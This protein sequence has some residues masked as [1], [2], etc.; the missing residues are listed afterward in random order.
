M[1]MQYSKL[2]ATGLSVSRLCL[3]TMT[4]GRQCDEQA[5][6]AILDTALEG[7]ITFL[8]TASS[9]PM[10]SG[11][12]E[13]GRTEEILGRWL[14][15]RRQAVVLATKGGSRIGPLPWQAGA[16]RKHLLDAIDGSLR[17]LGTDYVDLY[18]VHHDDPST[19]LEETME[20][21]DTIVRTGKARYV[22]AS[23][24][25]AYRLALALGRSEARRLVKFVSVQPRYNLLFREV[26]RELFPLAAEE[27]I[28]VN[29][30]N[31]LAGGLLTGKYRSMTQDMP[32]DSR[33]AS[34][35]GKAN[36]RERYWHER[37]FATLEAVRAEAEKAG[38]S[39][40][41]L[42]VAWALANPVVTSAIIG[43][44]RPGQLTDSLVAAGLALDGALKARLDELTHEY[45]FGDASR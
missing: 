28:A 14:K 1:S 9:Y 12:E 21:L 30:Y 25:L 10:E 2:G 29:V 18:Q 39:V 19:P 20:A 24:F 8:D 37:Q 32:G 35:G 15:G 13:A 27:K 34:A 26:E 3:G 16:S 11:P 7:G 17:R 22:G 33:F 36:Y 45:R 6:R 4:F 40:A 43:A 31:P 38:Q 42:A 44:S 23:N 5:S 41:T